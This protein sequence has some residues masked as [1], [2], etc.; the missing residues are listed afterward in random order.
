MLFDQFIMDDSVFDQT[1]VNY[2]Y[3]NASNPQLFHSTGGVVASQTI[4]SQTIASQT[5]ASQTING[6]I[7]VVNDSTSYSNGSL[8][9]NGGAGV[10][11]NVN[12]GGNINVVSDASFNSKLSVSSDVSFTSNLFVGGR[13]NNS[14]LDG[15]LNAKATTAAPSFTGI[16]TSAGDVSMNSRLSVLSDVSLNGNLFVGRR[17]GIGKNADIS[18]SLDLSG[19][20][21]LT[22]NIFNNGKLFNSFDYN[23]DMSLNGN[24][25]IVKKSTFN[26]DVSMNSKLIVASDV[27]FNSKLSVANT[28]TMT[29]KASI[30]LTDGSSNITYSD[31]TAQ[32]SAYTGAGSLAGIYNNA[33]ITVDNQGKIVALS[34]GVYTGLPFY[35]AS[36]ITSTAYPDPIIFGWGNYNSWNPNV[37][38]TFKVSLSVIYGTDYVSVYTLNCHLNIYPYRLVS[39]SQTSLSVQTNNLETNAINGDSSYFYTNA[40]YAPYGRYFWAHGINSTGTLNEGYVQIIISAAGRWGFQVKNPNVGNPCIISMVVDQTNKAMGGSVSLENISAYDNHYNQ[41]FGS[42]TSSG[43]LGLPY[44]QATITTSSS[45]PTTINLGWSNYTSW[46]INVFS[47]FKVSISVI[48]GTDYGSIYTLDCYINIYPRRLVSASQTSLISQITNIDS[49]AINGNT[50][51]SYVD[52]TYAPNGR[53]FWAHGINSTGTMNGGYVQM[54]IAAGGY[55]GFQIKNPNPGNP[56]TISMMVEQTNKAIGGTLTLENISIGYD[57]YYTQGFN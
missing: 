54:V 22:G 5:I 3:N 12:I 2:I 13:I 36:I 10:Y 45:Y 48:H 55:W 28:L 52:A 31:S 44:Y 35:Q 49:N 51:F 7:G 30:V 38:S 47:T 11:G 32:S 1:T 21:N 53:Y 14:W 42:F 50:S 18:F 6:F 17:I 33:S 46:N 43:Y 4:A 39:S 29:N 37:F 40:T 34:N 56:Y 41:G 9:V 25:T 26:G 15:S 19:N 23:S 8:V 20:L 16:I 27:S 57:H 24:L